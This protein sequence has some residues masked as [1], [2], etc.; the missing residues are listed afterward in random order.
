MVNNTKNAKGILTG[1]FFEYMSAKVPILAIG[2]TDGDL[3][4]IINKTQTGSISDFND[5]KGLEK[6][7]LDFFNGKV[8][9]R[10]E[11]EVNNYSRRSLTKQLCEL[12]KQLS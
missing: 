9:S 1:K 2:P 10:N 6:N 5:E 11:T 8:N 3:A 7:I 12:L 4:E